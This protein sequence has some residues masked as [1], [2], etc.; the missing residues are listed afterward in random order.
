MH[1]K[2]SRRRHA[3]RDNRCGLGVGITT[4]GPDPVGQ[5]LATIVQPTTIGALT[6]REPSVRPHTRRL[7]PGLGGNLLFT[8]HAHNEWAVLA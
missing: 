4:A 1:R 5:H 2:F 7:N 8:L 3:Q 6:E